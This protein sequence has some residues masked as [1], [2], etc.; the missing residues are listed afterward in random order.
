[1]ETTILLAILVPAGLGGLGALLGALAVRGRDSKDNA[2]IGLGVGLGTAAGLISAQVIIAGWPDFPPIDIAHWF[3]FVA[4]AAALLCIYDTIKGDSRIAHGL[5]MAIIAMVLWFF[6]VAPTRGLPL[7]LIIGILASWLG[8]A[9]IWYQVVKATRRAP[10]AGWPL[11]M[12]TGSTLLSLSLV[13]SYNAFLGQLAG[14]LAA[15]FGAITAVALVFRRFSL[16]PGAL[17][18]TLAA[19]IGLTLS[20]YLW[21]SLPLGAAILLGVSPLAGALAT[22]D[23]EGSSLGFSRALLVVLA[24]GLVAGA[25]VLWTYLAVGG[26]YDAMY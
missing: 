5:H 14:A 9:W 12:M 19:W 15:A 11:A 6:G 25:G 4:F 7:S 1:M 22:R 3:P 20:G 8:S 18:P 2:P 23:G 16:G 26:A 13:M 10:G 21:A 17:T 24:V